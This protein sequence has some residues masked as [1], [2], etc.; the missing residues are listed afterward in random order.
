L[1][2]VI[3]LGFAGSPDKLAAG[4]QVAGMDV[5]GL[6]PEQAREKL[7]KASAGH[8]Y[9]QVEFAV[10]SKRFRIAPAQLAVHVDWAAAVEAARNDSTGLGPLRGF[11]RL[12]VRFFGADIVPPIEHSKPA[13]DRFL[14]K[15]AK[16]VDRPAREPAIVIRNNV[17]VLVHGR[18]GKLLDRRVAADIVVRALASLS[19]RPATLP[20]RV[21]LP[22]VSEPELRPVLTEVTTALSA[23]VLLDFGAVRWRIAPDEI[24]RMLELPHDGERELRIGGA[25]ADGYLKRLAKQIDRP[26]RDASFAADGSRIRLVPSRQGR[27]LD[28]EATAASLLRAALEPSRRIAPLS[29]DRIPPKRTTAEARAMGIT[30]V[31]GS[32]E[33]SFGGTPNRLHNVELVAKLLDGKFIAPGAVFSFNGTTGERTSAKGFLKAPVIINGELEDALGGGVCQVSTTVFNAAFEGGLPILE[34]TNHALFI[35]HYP[36]GR[37]ATVNWPS[38][39]LKFKNDTGHWLLLRTFSSTYTLRVTLYGTPQHRRVVSEAAPLQVTGPIPIK[40]IPDPTL[41]KGQKVVEEEGVPPQATSVRRRV[42]DAN[43]KLLYDNVWYSSYRAEPKVVR[44]G[45]KPPEEKGGKG[46]KKPKP[47][48]G[49][50]DTTTT[51]TTGTTTGTTS[52]VP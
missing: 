19:S 14:A 45:T 35:S 23:P 22:S 10:G 27:K 30:G 40:K 29:L 42:Y 49:G 6:T 17:P 9:D 7:E 1:L 43:G 18:S 46:G 36:L 37:D 24:G 32:Y 48:S 50:T 41:K 44:I 38:T 52:T 34:R 39:D 33:T 3:G 26:A 13:L 2:L 11:K 15:I 5:G 47:P 20:V 28:S 4:V 12:Q 16:A 21:D 31:V 25:V 51:E 8:A